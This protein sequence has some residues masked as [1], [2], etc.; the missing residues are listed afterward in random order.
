MR[1][2]ILEELWKYRGDFVSGGKLAASLGIS[3]AAVWKH[4]EA[5]KKDGYDITG[6]TGKGYSLNEVDSIIIPDVIV[7]KTGNRLIGRDIKFFPRI[8]ST[9]EALKRLLRD[10]QVKEGMVIAAGNQEKAKAAW[11]GTG[12]L[13]RVACGSLCCCALLYRYPG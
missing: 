4:I 9:N 8:D 3:R 6:V 12:N 7:N 5:L 2:Q 10:G 13:R 11:E 1:E